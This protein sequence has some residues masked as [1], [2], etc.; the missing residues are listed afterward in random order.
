MIIS[1]IPFIIFNP[2]NKW[3]FPGGSVVKTPPAV[4]EPQETRVQP[5]G[6]EDPLEEQYSR[7]GN[8]MN[9]GVWRA[10]VH[11]VAKSQT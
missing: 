11:G 2:W 3:G 5:L 10:T 9:R 1:K 8:C 7:L 4:Q 6:R